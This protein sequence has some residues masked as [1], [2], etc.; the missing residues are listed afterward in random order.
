V[1]DLIASL[2]RTKPGQTVVI[3][4][5]GEVIAAVVGSLKSQPVKDWEELSIENASVTVVEAAAGKPPKL[6]LVNVS[7]GGAKR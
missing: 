3:V 5:H 7:L 1:L 2:E 4:T 6:A